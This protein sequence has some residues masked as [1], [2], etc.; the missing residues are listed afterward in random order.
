MELRAS[1][2]LFFFSVQRIGSVCYVTLCV[3]SVIVI[4]MLVTRRVKI[5]CTSI[6]FSLCILSAEGIKA[7]PL[8]LTLMPWRDAVN[9]PVL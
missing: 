3:L 6:K 7:V 8:L 2:L 1:V 9:P 5:W 4:A